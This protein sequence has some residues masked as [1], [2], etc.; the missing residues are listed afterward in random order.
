MDLTGATPQLFPGQRALRVGSANRWGSVLLGLIC[1]AASTGCHIHLA[2]EAPN[3][4][5]ASEASETS[6][7]AKAERPVI[8]HVHLC[9]HTPAAEG[10]EPVD[11][12][13]AF[14]PPPPLSSTSRKQ[15]CL[16]PY[17]LDATGVRMFR[18]ECLPGVV[19]AWASRCDMPY[20]VESSGIRTYRPECL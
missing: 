9:Q 12:G 4:R 13:G 18:R 14:G 11:P 8:V 19:G 10:V 5:N 3:V 16:T 1:V 2:P 20:A 6:E 15:A 7:T 17:R